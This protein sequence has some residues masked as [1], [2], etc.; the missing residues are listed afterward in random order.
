MARTRRKLA[1]DFP[2]GAARLVRETGKPI[3]QV[4]AHLRRSACPGRALSS[5]RAP[6]RMADLRLA[7]RRAPSAGEPHSGTCEP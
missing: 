4:A 2:E 5:C 1:A 7:R 3:T 6:P